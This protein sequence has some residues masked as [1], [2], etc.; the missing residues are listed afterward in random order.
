MERCK[1]CGGRVIGG[2]C[3]ECNTRTDATPEELAKNKNRV[4]DALIMKDKV[5]NE[6]TYSNNDGEPELEFLYGK[7]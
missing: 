2:K 5:V 1:F 7:Q 3:T 4:D 6:N